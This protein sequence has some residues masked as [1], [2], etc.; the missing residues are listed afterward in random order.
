MTDDLSPAGLAADIVVGLFS[1][2][3]G[4]RLYEMESKVDR[5]QEDRVRP[6]S[7]YQ[8]AAEK[9]TRL[10]GLHLDDATLEKAGMVFHYGLGMR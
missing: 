1:G 5:D 9:T 8:I 6:G 3:V 7:P 2:Y 4:T 10:M